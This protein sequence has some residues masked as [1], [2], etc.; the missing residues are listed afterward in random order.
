[1]WSSSSAKADDPVR[2][3]VSIPAQVGDY[4]IPAFAGK[5]AG[6]CGSPPIP[7]HPLQHLLDMRDRG[8]GQDAVAEVEDQ[9]AGRVICKHVVDRRIERRATGDQR[10]RIEI[11]LNGYA[12]LHPLADQ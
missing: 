10:Q 6:V 5:I 11:A 3:D 7:P 9:P 1:M 8:F 4:W 12:A 2:R